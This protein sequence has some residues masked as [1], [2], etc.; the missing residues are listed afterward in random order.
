MQ[1]LLS[2]LRVFRHMWDS[3]EWS[4]N[5]KIISQPTGKARYEVLRMGTSHFTLFSLTLD[6]SR[7]SYGRRTFVQETS[8][9]K[10]Q[11]KYEKWEDQNQYAWMK[12]ME[13]NQ[14]NCEFISLF[15]TCTAAVS[16]M[17][18]LIILSLSFCGT[19]DSNTELY[20]VKWI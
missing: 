8:M 18:L 19:V 11:W 20:R 14:L 5:V 12:P 3:H 17:K 13:I 4:I 6:R 10:N 15:W 7:K 2:L 1:Y 16:V 9:C